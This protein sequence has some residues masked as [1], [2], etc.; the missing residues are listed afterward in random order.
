MKQNIGKTDRLIR[1]SIAVIIDLFIL[2]N[3]IN[4]TAAII[5]GILS[6]I[7]LITALLKFCPLYIPFGI[8]TK[9]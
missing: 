7:L 9:K 8:S 5:L 6:G 3:I 4:G 1:I 2:F